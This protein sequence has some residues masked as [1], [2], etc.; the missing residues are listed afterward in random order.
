MTE[1]APPAQLHLLEVGRPRLEWIERSWCG[2]EPRRD[3]GKHAGSHRHRAVHVAFAAPVGRAPVPTPEAVT[4]LTV[5][6]FRQETLRPPPALPPEGVPA[7][8]IDDAS[9]PVLRDSEAIPL[10]SVDR[11]ASV[12]VAPKQMVVVDELRLHPAELE[13]ELRKWALP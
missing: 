1:L 7:V 5:H 10:Q 13:L 12:G 2:N 4:E 6:G 11:L 3:V 8:D 9:V